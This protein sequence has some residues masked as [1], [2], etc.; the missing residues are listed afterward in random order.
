MSE[1]QSTSGTRLY[2]LLPAHIRQRD[3]ETGGPL[4]ALLDII[5]TQADAL[6]A[7]LARGYENLFIE[8]CEDWVIPYLAGL[9]GT[10]P[11]YDAS[12]CT[13]DA[14]AREAFPDLRG[15][16]LLL[17]IG[18]SARA[19]VA[20]TIALRRRKG[21]VSALADVA[22]Y[23]TGWP[24]VIVEG[25]MRTGRTAHARHVRPDLQTVHLPTRL[26]SALVGR[27]FDTTTRWLDVRAPDGAVGW[28]HPRHVTAAI[29]RHGTQSYRRVAA[30]PA[31]APWRFRLDP[32]G[33][34]R[35]LFTKETHPDEVPAAMAAGAVPSPLLPALLEADLLAH[36]DAPRDAAGNRP[37]YT[38]L[39][40]P[41]G[42]TAGAP[43]ACLGVWLDNA[44]VT[45][46]ADEA[47][48]AVSYQAQ[49]VSRRLDPWPAR[50]AGAVVAV[51]VRNGRLAVG[52]GLAVPATVTASL[53]HGTAG[54]IGG[55]SYDR[56]GWQL[57]TVPDARITVA[58]S[59]ADHATVTAA[60]TAWNASGAE[61]AII[62]VLDSGS[63]Q[64]PG[65]LALSGRTLAIEAANGERPVLAPD[66]ADATLTLAGA[67]RLTLSGVALDG[68]IVVGEAVEQL[69]LF[70]V[71]LPPGGRRTPD[72]GPLAAGPS[73]QVRGFCPRLRVQL[74]CSVLGPLEFRA[75]IDELLA[76]DTLVVGEGT[77]A[78]S[79]SGGDGPDTCAERCTF[80]GAVTVRSVT[81]TACL[82]AAGLFAARTQEGC[83]RYCYVRTQSRT[84][85]RF[86]CQPELAVREALDARPGMSTAERAALAG[87]ITRRTRPMF[88][89]ERFGDAGCGQL[90]PHVPEPI[91]TGAPDGSEIGAFSHVKQAQ[92]LENLRL[93]LDE[94]GPAGIAVGRT[95]IT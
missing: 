57:A 50:P 82:F 9:L 72:G 47:A 88:V 80:L 11:L 43:A 34:D 68:R 1:P 2:Q 28:Y 16:R 54:T 4:A 90:E 13:D 36:V 73:I 59:G 14:C 58:A 94:Y 86:A 18:A 41:A 19:D 64:L 33:L 84:P 55:G 6:S 39:Y 38:T 85:R 74:A 67:G 27:P 3:A 8:T 40:G 69:R 62:R 71:T 56:A 26:D 17:P 44:F 21:T 10:T 45:P 92:R 29:Y 46:A 32:L 48:P 81:A 78:I 24:V 77:D 87:L 65:N 60:V 91:A 7:D 31:G 25:V 95:V 89:S 79:V 63:Y 22:R 37:G 93:R 5:G 75:D 30:R 61:H 83:L 23:A 20:R 53:H 35:A 12:R 66:S 70:H 42:E 15:P 49:L 51:D 52:S 76:L